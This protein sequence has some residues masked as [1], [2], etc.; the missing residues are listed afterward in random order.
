MQGNKNGRDLKSICKHSKEDMLLKIKR[1]RKNTWVA[2]LRTLPNE[3]KKRPE[4]AGTDSVCGGR[5]SS[6]APKQT[7]AMAAELSCAREECE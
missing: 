5:Q 4:A 3:E 2:D 7:S 6:S 1:Q